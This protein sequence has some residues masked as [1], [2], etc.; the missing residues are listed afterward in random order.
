MDTCTIGVILKTMPILTAVF[1]IIIACVALKFN[2][3]THTKQTLNLYIQRC[4]DATKDDG[5]EA[6]RECIGTVITCCW[7]ACKYIEN[8]SPPIFLRYI[9]FRSSCEQKEELK[10]YFWD[11]LPFSVWEEI[12]KKEKLSEFMQKEN[13]LDRDKDVLAVQYRSII[14]SFSKQI[15]SA[16]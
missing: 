14:E 4:N 11:L 6:S 2:Y 15:K 9:D 10:N 7:K 5:M 1:S 3:D 16:G 13:S 12:I 8:Y